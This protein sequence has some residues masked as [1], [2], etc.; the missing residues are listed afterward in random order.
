MEVPKALA[1]DPSDKTSGVLI[2]DSNDAIKEVYRDI[3]EVTPSSILNWREK[4]SFVLFSIKDF[5]F[6]LFHRNRLIS[7]YLDTESDDIRANTRS[8]VKTYG[9]SFEQKGGHYLS[10]QEIEQ[11]ASDGLLGPFK[12]SV[13]SEKIAKAHN[14]GFSNPTQVYPHLYS[15]N[16]LD[17]ALD[18]AIVQRV[19]SILGGEV[20]IA[21]TSL[22]VKQPGDPAAYT[23]WHMNPPL[24][25]GSS[26]DTDTKYLTVWIALSNATLQH[27]CLKVIP[28]S[29]KMYPS[30]LVPRVMDS[31]LLL[32][33]PFDS[34]LNSVMVKKFR[35]QDD[36]NKQTPSKFDKFTLSRV[37]VASVMVRAL[38]YN[39]Y[40]KSFVE[41]NNLK[42]YG[43][44]ASPGEFYMFVSENFHASLPNL[45]DEARVAM[46]IRFMKRTADTGQVSSLQTIINRTPEGVKKEIRQSD[47]SFRMPIFAT[48]S[49]KSGVVG[50]KHYLTREFLQSHVKGYKAE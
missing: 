6:K 35:Q 7:R 27:G 47:G 38:C 9:P 36:R 29:Y 12:T 20:D 24:N 42:A 39:N 8:R 1:T 19:S 4:I 50:G 37:N 21:R 49:A 34:F 11:F 25:W 13:G 10:Q 2:A 33:K 18:P 16:F 32:D 3:Y 26:E 31:E 40:F 17:I 43:L 44:P 22:F 41:N 30:E 14:H 23:R 48:D 45:S 28:R 46:V 15:E 5:F